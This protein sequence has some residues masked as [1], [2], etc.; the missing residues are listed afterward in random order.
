MSLSGPGPS[1]GSSWASLGEFWGASLW[2]R[3]RD[4]G[5]S[6]GAPRDLFVSL[7]PGRVPLGVSSC[8][9]GPLLKPCPSSGAV[10]WQSHRSC[11]SQGVLLLL[12]GQSQGRVTQMRQGPG[13]LSPQGSR[14]TELTVAETASLRQGSSP[15]SAA[16]PQPSEPQP[17]RR[18]IGAEEWA[19]PTGC[20]LS[21]PWGQPELSSPLLEEYLLPPVQV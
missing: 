7:G 5:S 14:S 11:H 8:S 18:T 10:H 15:A 12:K 16:L 9:W 2:E 6:L 20:S 19:S 21:I 4:S 17:A 13:S 1:P 3:C